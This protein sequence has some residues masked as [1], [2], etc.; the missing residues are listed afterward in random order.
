MHA[1]RHV[2]WCHF[3]GRNRSSRIKPGDLPKKDGVV[4]WTF[5]IDFVDGFGE[6]EVIVE[7]DSAVVVSIAGK[8][9]IG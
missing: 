9:E 6:D 3:H 1:S 7:G 2:G 8:E 5:R 4:A